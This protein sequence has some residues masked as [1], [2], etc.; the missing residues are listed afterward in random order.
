MCVDI[1]AANPSATDGVYI[2]DPDGA[3]GAEPFEAYCDMTTDG[4][5][6]TIVFQSSD[7]STWR[8]NTGTPGIG[9]W[10]FV[11]YTPQIRD[12]KFH[13]VPIQYR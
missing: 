6:W 3:D 12:S 4:G 7:P 9:E 5:G 8:T 1:L 13:H 2:I 11:T 10:R